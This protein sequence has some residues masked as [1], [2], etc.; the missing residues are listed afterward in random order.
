M[1]DES[2]TP[3]EWIEL[4]IAQ[5]RLPSDTMT[6]LAAAHERLA[7]FEQFLN[8]VDWV[9]NYDPD[10]NDKALIHHLREFMDERS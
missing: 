1:S 10:C 9:G 8:F 5:R 4:A 6:V 2:K 7:D 3:R